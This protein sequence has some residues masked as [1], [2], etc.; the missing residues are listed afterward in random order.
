MT[1]EA[2]AHLALS[3]SDLAGARRDLDAGD[4]RLAVTRAYY[5]VFHAAGAALIAEGQA[6]KSHAGTNALFAR[7]LV[8]TGKL[9][10]TL[11]RVLSLLMELRHEADYHVGG[12]ISM[13]EGEKAVADATAFVAAVETLLSG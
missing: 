12:D 6:P 7:L 11:S 13:T 9:D 8:Q 1:E 10:R 4:P 5:A 3:A 2:R